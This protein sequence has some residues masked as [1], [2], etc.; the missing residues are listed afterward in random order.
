[1]S[2]SSRQG[3]ERSQSSLWDP[4][5]QAPWGQPQQERLAPCYHGNKAVW[6]AHSATIAD[7]VSLWG[8][9]AACMEHFVP[10]NTRNV[11]I[12]WNSHLLTVNPE[13][14]SL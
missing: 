3:T 2:P 13:N 12:Y 11:F 6:G 7:H 10:P 14:F 4:N 9:G 8:K 1:M 5:S